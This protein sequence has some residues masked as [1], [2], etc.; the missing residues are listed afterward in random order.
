MCNA[1]A[2]SR[3][4]AIIQFLER[5]ISGLCETYG[6]HD[7]V[8]PHRIRSGKISGGCGCCVRVEMLLLFYMGVDQGLK[9]LYS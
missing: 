7:S 8:L 5:E 9:G 2:R 6:F 3:P 4:T 1:A